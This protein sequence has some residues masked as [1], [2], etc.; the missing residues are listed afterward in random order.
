M[1]RTIGAFDRTQHPTADDAFLLSLVQ[2]GEEQAMA[3]LF[4]RYSKVVYSVALRVLSDPA[5]AEDILQD[6]FMQLWRT[7]D[8]F[9]AVGGSLGGWLAVLSRN[10]SVNALRR[11]QHADPMDAIA[12]AAP[13]DLASEAERNRLAEN[14]RALLHQ[15]P[16]E[17]RKA[18]EMALFDGLTHIEIAEVTGE[19]LAAVKS[20]LHSALLSLREACQP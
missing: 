7:P 9:T 10:R 16:N 2:A 12:F 11:K 14:A 3:T 6:V 20:T 18:M 5:L 1:D 19:P 4:D 17:Q 13:I 15:L 8:S